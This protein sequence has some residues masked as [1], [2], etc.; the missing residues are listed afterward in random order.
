MLSKLALSGVPVASIRSLATSSAKS[1]RFGFRN[2]S[3]GLRIKVKGGPTLRE[4]LLGPTSG[5]PFVYGTYAIAGASVFG[6]GM[7]CYYGLGLSKGVSAMDRAALWPEHVRHRL[8]ATYAYLASSLAMTAGVGVMASRTP[9]ILALT[10]SGGL[11]VFIGSLAA[12]IGTG[13]LVRSIDYDSNRIAKHLA[14][15]AHCGVMGAVLAPLCLAGG[16]VLLRAAWY[17][18]GLCA[19]LSAT[20]MCAPSEKFLMM[21]GPLAMGLGVVFV[22]NI[23]S[24]FFPAH[25]ALGAGLASVVVYGGLILFSMFLLYDTQ[26]IIHKAEK[27]PTGGVQTFYNEYGQPVQSVLARGF[28]P[29]DAQLSLYMDILN[30][31]IRLVMIMGGGQRRK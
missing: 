10:S 1:A 12:I 25:T 30:I 14:W 23:G 29:I 22:A 5:K 18:A 20:A 9:A 31:F 27:H 11:M 26:R 15:I 13:M 8:Q 24:F 16:P 17:T 6:V 21:G 4:R 7:L 28:D 19:G 2:V 3:D